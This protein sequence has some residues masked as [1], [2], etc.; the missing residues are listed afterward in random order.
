MN[1]KDINMERILTQEERIR[2]AEEIYLKRRSI[3]SPQFDKVEKRE[4]T[5]NKVETKSIGLFKKIGLQ[6]IICLLLYCIFYLIYDTN[7]SFSKITISKIR[8]VLD[9]DVN[10]EEL[11][12]NA[13]AYIKG[14][15]HNNINV[16]EDIPIEKTE[17]NVEINEEMNK[18]EQIKKD[19]AEEKLQ[20]NTEQ[21][22]QEDITQENAIQ[23]EEISVEEVDLKQIYS[24]IKPVN[25]GYISSEF[26]E[27]ESTS[28]IVSTNH[29]GI[30]IAIEKRCKYCCCNRGKSNNCYFIK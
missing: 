8:E 6:I 30:D 18:E 10:I 13:N 15:L 22:I 17:S 19:G 4:L 16:E 12:K 27:R 9:Y 7:F 24:L 23:T 11:Y 28:E 2:R 5:N 21:L 20:V 29:K 25:G 26:G 3:Q 1:R 14:L